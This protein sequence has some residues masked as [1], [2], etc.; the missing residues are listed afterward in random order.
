MFIEPCCISSELHGWFWRESD[1]YGSLMKFCEGEL[2]LS[3][4]GKHN[5]ILNNICVRPR[6]PTAIKKQ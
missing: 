1:T 6:N 3:F 2:E 5:I 4:K